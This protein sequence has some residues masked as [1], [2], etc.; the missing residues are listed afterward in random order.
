M[1][2]RKSLSLGLCWPMRQGIECRIIANQSSHALLVTLGCPLVSHLVSALPTPAIGSLGVH[3]EVLR[4]GPKEAVALEFLSRRLGEQRLWLDPVILWDH[5]SVHLRSSRGK[6]NQRRE[7][8]HSLANLL[9]AESAELCCAGAHDVVRGG[10]VLL[11]SD[12]RQ[13]QTTD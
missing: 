11:G 6:E 10:D 12:L 8:C 5:R 2:I 4:L 3:H 7:R 1:Q 9:V 13:C